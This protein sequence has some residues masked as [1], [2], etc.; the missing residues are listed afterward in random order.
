VRK[1][2]VTPLLCD[3]V[4]DCL[5]RSS[6]VCLIPRGPCL[7]PSNVAYYRYNK[8][9]QVAARAVR[10]SLKEGERVKAEKRGLTSLRYQQWE[11]GKAGE[12]V[13]PACSSGRNR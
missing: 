11:N 4:L 10:N 9:T 7:A 2:T 13:G 3:Y 12:Q 1:V 5:E 6:L 8:Y